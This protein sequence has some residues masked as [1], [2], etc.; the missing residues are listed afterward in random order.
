MS[1]GV[2]LDQA[3]HA[4][5]KGVWLAALI[6][7]VGGALEGILVLLLVSAAVGDSCSLGSLAI[8][9]IPAVALLL[10]PFVYGFGRWRGWST[11]AAWVALGL[12]LVT[13]FLG[14]G[15]LFISLFL[16]SC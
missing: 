12:T 9:W 6:I 10:L 13:T 7:S 3:R 5:A 2:R 14:F 1:S 11:T 4:Q 15:L 16:D 8:A